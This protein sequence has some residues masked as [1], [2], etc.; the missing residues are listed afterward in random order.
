MQVLV[1]IGTVGASPQIGEILLLCDFLLTVLSCPF[2]SG[3]RP[4]QVEPLDRFSRSM[5][6][7]MC[8]CVRK[9]LWG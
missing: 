5:A 7:T 8:F 1:L 6:Q 9:C 4:L 3:T 2:I